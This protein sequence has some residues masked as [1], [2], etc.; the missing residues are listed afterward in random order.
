MVLRHPNAALKPILGR[1]RLAKSGQKPLKSAF[2]AAQK[3]SESSGGHSQNVRKRRSHRPTQLEAFAD[4]F[5]NAFGGHAT[6]PKCVSYRSCQCFIDVGRFAPQ[7]LA[8]RKIFE[9]TVVSGSK[10]EARGVLGTLGRASSSAKTAKSSEKARPKCPRGLRK[11]ISG[12]ERSNFQRESASSAPD[13][14][15][16]PR[17]CR[18]VISE[19]SNGYAI[20]IRTLLNLESSYIVG[21][22][23][24]F[25]PCLGG[26]TPQ[27]RKKAEK[28]TIDLRTS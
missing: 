8:V 7:T 14:R 12:R 9:K 18:A 1:P 19:S 11:F 22:F 20:S 26:G 15:A 24:S 21:T 25:F 13:E 10:I 5:F 28:S 4:R 3:R 23:F 2:K 27:G 17:G 6:A 16:E